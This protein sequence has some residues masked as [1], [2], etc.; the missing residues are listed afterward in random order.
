MKRTDGHNRYVT[1]GSRPFKALVLLAAIVALLLTL[2]HSSGQ[3][4]KSIPRPD[5]LLL[6]LEPL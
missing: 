4:Q 6:P 5:P 3:S 1:S 2:H